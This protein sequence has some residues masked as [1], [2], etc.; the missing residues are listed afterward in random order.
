MKAEALIDNAARDKSGKPMKCGD[1]AEV[2]PKMAGAWACTGA[3]RI[4]EH[5]R[6]PPPAPRE[7]PPPQTSAQRDKVLKRIY[8]TD[9]GGQRVR[10][11]HAER[12]ARRRATKQDPP[13]PRRTPA[14][15][16]T[17]KRKESTDGG[18]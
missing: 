6:P 9:S 8:A 12:M 1:V 11:H 10:D 15:G 16:K 4:V 17:T 3:V 13:K 5:D 7:A 18:N 2:D 14:P